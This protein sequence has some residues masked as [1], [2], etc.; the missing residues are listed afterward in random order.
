MQVRIETV[1]PVEKKLIVEIPWSAVSTKLGQAY[2]ELAKT[3]TLKGFRR[4]KVPRSVI[5]QMFGR[6]VRAEVAA[7]LIQESFVAANSEHNLEAV[8]QPKIETLAEVR[9][10]EP[11]SFEALVEV[12]GTIETIDYEGLALTKRPLNISDEQVDRALAAVQR[13]HTELVPIEDR[14]ETT[15]RDVVAF[16]VSGTVGDQA[17]DNSNAVVDLQDPGSEPLPGLAAAL[18][19]VP[20]DLADHKIS[21]AIP[22]DYRDPQIAG[23]TA[24]LTV[25]VTEVREKDIPE[26]DDELAKDTGRATTLAE[27]RDLLRADLEARMQEEI[28]SELRSAALKELCKRN[29]IPVAA[30][31]IDRA[32]DLQLRRLSM[33]LGGND[34]AM[35]S[36]MGDEEMRKK[37]AP[38]ATDEVR[39][40]LLLEALAD[41]ENIEVD[42]EA[43][44][45]RV[46]E[47]AARQDMSPGRLRSE[48]N[49]DGRLDDLRFRVRQDRTLDLV[50]S[51]A[52]V[53]EAEPPDESAEAASPE[54]ASEAGGETP[55]ENE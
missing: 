19:G 41:K 36:A 49:R 33:L 16:N 28:D 20:F 9:R 1:S 37:L 43:L 39:G 25:S 47:V 42:D 11:F 4:G 21:L 30:S 10:G 6:R 46:A 34:D 18:T 35:R 12:R 29:P 54:T 17:I 2:G 32:I 13:E 14:T 38:S 3:V 24:E 23:K 45:A 55:S 26:L 40:Q 53:T 52:T 22:E 48:M 51:R 44:D 7:E 15:D 31:L 50:V 8:S 5:E 27:L